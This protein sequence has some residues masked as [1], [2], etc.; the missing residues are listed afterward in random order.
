M[1][2]A[3]IRS[4]NMQ[5]P[6]VNTFEEACD[7]IEHIG[8]LPLSSFIPDHPSLASITNA[9]AWHTGMET[10]PWLWRDFFAGEGVAAYGRF[11]AGKPIFISRELFPLV[12][13]MLSQSKSVADRYA[14]GNL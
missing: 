7:V 10:D 12:R 13:S 4:C 6:I 9:G 11:I 3:R 5:Y 1:K 8:I 2:P 14:A